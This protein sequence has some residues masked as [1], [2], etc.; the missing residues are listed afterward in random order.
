[1]NKYVEFK[2]KKS[3]D[4]DKIPCFFAF[5]NE[6]MERGKKKLNITNNNELVIIQGTGMYMIKSDKNLLDEFYSK[7][8]K[9]FDNLIKEDQ[10]GEGFITDM[11]YYELN[12]HE[13]SYTGRIG[14][15]LD[16]LGLTRKQIKETPNLLA[17]LK[18]ALEKINNENKD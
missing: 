13:Y 3:N 5:N 16:C 4:F 7:Y 2:T 15:A 14:E 18:N 8:E 11:F 9:E 12:N 10:T 17:G 6:Q 1:M